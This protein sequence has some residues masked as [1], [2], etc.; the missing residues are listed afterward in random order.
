MSTCFDKKNLSKYLA[1][2]AP[3][4]F[5]GRNQPIVPNSVTA[6]DTKL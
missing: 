5:W 3:K 4:L 2:N 1:E 6:E